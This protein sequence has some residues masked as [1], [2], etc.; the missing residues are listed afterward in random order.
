MM[1]MV[2]AALVGCLSLLAGCLATSPANQG[3]RIDE[4][5]M[6]GGMDRSKIPEL[7]AA[8]AKFISD[9][10]AQFGSR[11]QAAVLWVNRGFKLQHQ[12]QLGMAMRRF[13]QAWLLN[14]NNPEVYAGFGTV[15]HDQGRNCEAMKMM[16]KALALDPPTF[17]GIYADAA[18]VITLCAASDKSLPA[19][20]RK[21]MFERSE[22]LYR[23]AEVVEPNKRYVYASW[24][25][26]YYWRE[27]YSDAWSMV[28]KERAAG[29]VPTERFLSLLQTKMPEPGKVKQQ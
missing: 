28:A 26:A 11:E 14:P 9:V 5:P 10:S 13:N 23:K 21:Q 4:V 3:T 24:A 12:D 6:Y 8:D 20:S 27:Q 16:D 7:Q 15:L 1:K 17:Q 2:F 25:T 19:E 29:G 22:Q 18:R